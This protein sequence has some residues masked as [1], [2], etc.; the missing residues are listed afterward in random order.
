MNKA[1]L[2]AATVLFWALV[3]A[4]QEAKP[5]T[6][7]TPVRVYDPSR[8]AAQ[9]LLDAQAEAKA[10][11]K[12]VLVEVG[13]KWC[14]W[15]RIMDSFFEQ[16]PDMAELRDKNYVTVYVNFSK[17][18]ENQAV[19]GRYPEIRGYPHLFVLSSE[20]KLL[21][22][23]NTSELEEGRGYNLHRFRD[24]LLKWAPTPASRAAS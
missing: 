3:V 18:N 9:D 13:G 20:G 8:N 19:L 1:L 21:H 6:G 15:C 10:T 23:Q 7:Y 4:A 11:G 2:L 22:S 5:A 12:N 14:V 16:H 17:E 24:F